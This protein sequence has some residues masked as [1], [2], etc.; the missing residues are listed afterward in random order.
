[1]PVAL[2]PIRKEEKSFAELSEPVT[3]QLGKCSVAEFSGL[4]GK[5]LR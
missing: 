4:G 2:G 1:M 3:E 5:R